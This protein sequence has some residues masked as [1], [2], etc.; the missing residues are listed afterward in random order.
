L[1]A[2]I[3]HR[4]HLPAALVAAA[5]A[6][7]EPVHLLVAAVAAAVALLLRTAISSFQ[8][9]LPDKGRGIFPPSLTQVQSR[10]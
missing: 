6:V 2:R 9:P 1:N 7:L 4:P 8:I 3:H 10:I 5:A